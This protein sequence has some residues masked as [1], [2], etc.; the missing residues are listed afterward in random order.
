[1]RKFGYIELP[2]KC[3]LGHSVVIR[4]DDSDLKPSGDN[5]VGNMVLHHSRRAVNGSQE[6]RHLGTGYSRPR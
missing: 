4:T 3:T 6:R 5:V 2:I 1:M